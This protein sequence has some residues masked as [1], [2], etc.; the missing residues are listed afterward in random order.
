MWRVGIIKKDG[1]TDA[2]NFETKE[3]CE[4]WIL[5]KAEKEDLKKAI[6]CNKENLSEREIITF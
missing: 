6:Y 5:K 1:T 2:K 3:Q 4:E